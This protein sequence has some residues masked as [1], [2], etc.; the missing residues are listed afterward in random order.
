MNEERI[1]FGLTHAI[2]S[3]LRFALIGGHPG[4][5]SLISSN[6]NPNLN[7]SCGTALDSHQT[8]PFTSD[9]C[10]PSEPIKRSNYP[11]LRQ[12]WQ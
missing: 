7:D 4:S 3:E 11:T 8:F 9:G 2:P 1:P 5:S 6:L 10:S 12:N